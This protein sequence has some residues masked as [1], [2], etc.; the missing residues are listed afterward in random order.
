LESKLSV[1]Q[2][3]LGELIYTMAKSGNSNSTLVQ[4]YIDQI[5][6]VQAQLADI[7]G[8]ANLEKFNCDEFNVCEKCGAFL[9]DDEFVCPICSE[10]EE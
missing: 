10:N 7:K 5:D 6:T 3:K 2:R 8:G 9:K 4:K 1:L